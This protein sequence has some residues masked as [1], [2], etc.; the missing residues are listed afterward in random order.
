MKKISTIIIAM[1][2]LFGMAQC[3]KQETPA[4]PNA[5][6]N[7]V[8]I[9]MKVGGGD[10]HI[11][12]PGTGAVVYGNGD[13]IYVGDGS[14]YLGTLSFNDGVF[15]GTIT[16]PAVGDYLYFYFLGGLTITPS[17]TTTSYTVNIANQSQK[18]PV[19][20]CG[21][22]SAPYSTSNTTY[23]SMLEN[24]CAL[25][26]FGLTTGTSDAVS[27]AGMRTGATINFNN[28]ESPI[29]AK[30]STGSITL[31]S[32]GSTEKWAILLPQNAVSNANVTIGSGSGFTVDVPATTANGYIT[33]GIEIDNTPVTGHAI[34]SAVK[35][36][37]ICD[38]NLAYAGSFYNRLPSGVNAIALVAYVDDWHDYILALALEDEGW[39]TMSWFNAMDACYN[40]DIPS[41]VSG[42]N[43]YWIL[44]EYNHWNDMI[45]AA[46]GYMNLRNC[47]ESVGGTNMSNEPWNG[48]W[49][50]DADFGLNTAQY[51][52]FEHG[53]WKS[54]NMD[55][56][57]HVRAVLYID[58]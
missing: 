37:L 57:M 50:G 48:Y 45:N 54:A 20:S 10:R 34:A 52:N 39:G 42:D 36:D 2:L 46:G 14:K 3:K 11:V 4:T 25:V 28:P 18:L 51:Y 41:S 22:S 30:G 49:S 15:G 43:V 9:T 17:A 53:W 40:K 27:V 38:D 19:L 21:R 29:V 8:Y 16:E 35:G 12:Y 47:F 44:G 58:L 6:G 26:K 56:E 5:E 13:V 24:K 1:A 23:S 7:E 55:E 31:K 33:S 32:E